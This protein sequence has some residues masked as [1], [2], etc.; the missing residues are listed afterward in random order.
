MLT[1]RSTLRMKG[2]S[3]EAATAV[4]PKGIG[5][6]YFRRACSASMSRSMYWV[7]LRSSALA[8]SSTMALIDGRI[9]RLRI[10]VFA[11]VVVRAM[12]QH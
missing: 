5:G 7:T 2:G 3:T 10:A 12:A 9:R 4:R 8:R 1:I 11:S 6:A